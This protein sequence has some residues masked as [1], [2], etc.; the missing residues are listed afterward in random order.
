MWPAQAR[1]ELTTSWILSES[2][3][4]RLPQPMESV[5]LRLAETLMEIAKLLIE[6]D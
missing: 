4:T 5:N 1:L 2:N 3:I 6:R